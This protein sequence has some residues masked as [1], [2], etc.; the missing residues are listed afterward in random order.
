MIQ[1]IHHLVH[2]AMRGLYLF[3]SLAFD[4]S[5]MDNYVTVTPGKIVNG[6]NTNTKIIIKDDL[7]RDVKT[8]GELKFFLS[9]GVAVEEG[10]AE[11][12][13]WRRQSFNNY[14]PKSCSPQTRKQ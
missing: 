14:S 11:E 10:F 6:R 9:N 1:A 4:D 12:C 7:E 2:W 8:Y 13:S 3:S 5:G